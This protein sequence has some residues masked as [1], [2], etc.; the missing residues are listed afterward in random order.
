MGKATIKFDS[1][2]PCLIRSPNGFMTSDEFREQMN[3]GLQLLIEK[4]SEM[5]EIAWLADA[6]KQEV[7]S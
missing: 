6:R 4:K 1:S 3:V 2:V 5:L 7:V